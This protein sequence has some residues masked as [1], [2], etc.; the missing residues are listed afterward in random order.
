MKNS[1]VRVIIS[2]AA[3]IIV[4]QMHAYQYSFSNHTKKKIAVSIKF[5]GSKW[6]EFCVV[7]PGQMGSIAHG[8]KYM[9][10]VQTDFPSASAGLIPSQFFYYLPKAGERMTTANQQ[11]VSW[12]AVNITWVP[13]E[14]YDI[15]IDLADK[16]GATGETV[17]K[18][19]AKAGAAYATGG[20]STA[21]E[22]ASKIT[23]T[24]TGKA[25]ALKEAAAGEYGLGKLLST[26]G[27]SAARSLIGDHH[28]DIVED[29][30]GV[31]SFIS[32]L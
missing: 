17:G 16:F 27:K 26:I 20:A 18:T 14:S 30:K 24:A 6:Y 28:I 15:A 19:A 9:P 2:V 3:F 1:L 12:R 23:Q 10:D 13:S 31:I 29:E 4:P 7:L 5:K 32:L 25:D 22:G 8:N 11:T 21:A